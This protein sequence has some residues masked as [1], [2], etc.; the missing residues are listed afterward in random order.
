MVAVCPSL[1]VLLKCLGVLGQ[2]VLT[3]VESIL[4]LV[5]RLIGELRSSFVSVV[6]C[7]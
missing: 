1:T 6:G 7:E 2:N 5:N 3:N 4:T